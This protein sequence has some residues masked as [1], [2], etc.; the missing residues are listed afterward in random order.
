MAARQRKIPID[1]PNVTANTKVG[2]LTVTQFVTLI[3]QISDALVAERMAENAR[4]AK[5]VAS[6]IK[7]AA[8]PG[9]DKQMAPYTAAALH[10]LLAPIGQYL[11][12]VAPD[13]KGFAAGLESIATTM[14]TALKNPHVQRIFK[15]M[16]SDT[17]AEMKK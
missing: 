16:G 3:S 5:K 7:K 13:V 2:D 8:T 6:R 9:F 4:L 14:D 10:S 12:D 17:A 15:E 1:I 11:T